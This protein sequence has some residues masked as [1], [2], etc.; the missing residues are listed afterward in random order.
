LPPFGCGQRIGLYGGTF[1]PPHEGHRQIALI[2]LH[3]LQLDAIWWLVT[4]GN[5]LKATEG[6]VAQA[7]RMDAAARL[8]AHPR[9]AVS[10]VEAKLNTR[11]TADLATRLTRRVETVRFVWIMGSDNLADFHRWDR[12]QDIAGHFPIAVINRPGTLTAPMN[13]PAA[14]TLARFRAR[15]S[16]ANRLAFMP[17]P[18]WIYLTGPRTSASSTGIRNAL[19]GRPVTKN[20]KNS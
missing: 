18:A 7:E 4:P 17:P 16:A 6:L 2:A 12:W 14:R 10:G 15:E 11:Y 3:R 1:N 9:M 13:A 8:A 19:N 20:A 5:P